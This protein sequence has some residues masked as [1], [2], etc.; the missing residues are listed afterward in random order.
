MCVISQC[1]NNDAITFFIHII[2]KNHTHMNNRTNMP[3]MRGQSMT[4]LEIAEV[5]LLRH[6]RS[7]EGTLILG[8][9]TKGSRVYKIADEFI[10]EVTR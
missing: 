8:V 10:T 6:Q 7:E 9:D 1:Q 4:S 3:V 5:S 2:N